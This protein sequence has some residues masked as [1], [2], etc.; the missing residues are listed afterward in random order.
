MKSF[1]AD[2]LSILFLNATYL[3]RKTFF[4]FLNIETSSVFHKWKLHECWEANKNFWKTYFHFFSTDPSCIFLPVTLSRLSLVEDWSSGLIFFNRSVNFEQDCLARLQSFCWLLPG[5]TE[6]FNS[7][8][9]NFLFQCCLTH[10]CYV[11]I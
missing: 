1:L 5:Y 7:S 6:T 4:H 10:Q 11:N 2:L 3:V 9:Q 8:L